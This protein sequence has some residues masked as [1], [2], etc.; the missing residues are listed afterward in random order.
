MMQQSLPVIHMF[1]HGAPL[2]RMERLCLTSFQANGHPVQLHVYEP[3][4]GV[5]AGIE[6][7]DAEQTLSR[8]HIF[9]HEQSKSVAAFADWFRYRVLH[10]RGGIWADT[11][12]VCLKPLN[13]PGTEVF[14]WMDETAINNAVLG[15]RAGH[16]LAAWMAECCE[17]P[18]RWRPYDDTRTRRR[19][20]K[21]RFLRGNR[22]GDV[23]WG[24]YGPQGFTQAARHF[25]EQDKALPF[26]HFYP[27]HYLNWH[28]VFDG[29]LPDQPGLLEASHALHLWNEK[30]RQAPGGFDK[31]GRFAPA[32]L[33]ERLCARY[34]TND[35]SA[36]TS[37]P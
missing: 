8:Q 16:Q 19:K 18:N 2:S 23:K 34:L 11:D 33:F 35:S 27:I 14:G 22:R 21:R 17:H 3:P 30:T 32:S 9:R 24:E 37:R 36:P 10:A 6:L 25:G 5:P 31:N 20:L 4:A 13:Y 12:V 7:V 1:W 29:S 15:L 28:T 26:W